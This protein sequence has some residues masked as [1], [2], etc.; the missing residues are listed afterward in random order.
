MEPFYT[1]DI[2]PDSQKNSE[3]KKENFIVELFKFTVIALAVVLPIRFF[4]A[5][6]F[7][8]Q[9]ASMDPTFATGEYLIINQLGYHLGNPQR[10]DVIVFKF[11]KDE[12]KYFIKRVIGLPGEEVIIK[13][14]SVI[15]KNKDNPQGFTLPEPYISVQ[16]ERSET[17]D[18]GIIGTDQYFVMGDNRLQSYDSRS[19]GILSRDFIIG[20]PFVRLFP[21]AKISLFP[22][23]FKEEK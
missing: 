15:I 6:P 12:T 14:T 17:Y 22:G 18:S 7:V 3:P 1:K 20:T 19:W 5:Q 23:G 9:G 2:V 21:L 16:N 10:G 8:V 11:P 13:N 4:I